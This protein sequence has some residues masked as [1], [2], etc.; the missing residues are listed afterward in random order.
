MPEKPPDDPNKPRL[1]L[2]DLAARRKAYG[3]TEE[4]FLPDLAIE[5]EERAKEVEK[6]GDFTTARKMRAAAHALW[7]ADHL[8][9]AVFEAE[10]AKEEWELPPEQPPTK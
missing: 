6:A 1:T 3:K 7:A 2:V 8:A 9:M 5:F 10:W 4:P